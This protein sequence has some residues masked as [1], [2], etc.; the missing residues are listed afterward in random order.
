MNTPDAS[1]D[2]PVEKSLRRFY[3]ES[4]WKT[5]SSGATLD[6]QRW[7]DLRPCAAAYVSACRRRILAHLPKTGHV[8][9]DVASGPVQYP[10][11]AELSR[12]F[13]KHLCVDLSTRALEQARSRLGPRGLYVCAS[14]NHLPFADNT[15][16]AV[17]SLHTIYHVDADEQEASVRQ[18][19]RTVR[20]GGRVI[21]VYAN[22]DRL[23]SRLKRWLRP[24]R[25]APP[26]AIYYHAH[27]LTWWARFRD[28]ASLRILPWRSVVAQESKLLPA[29]LAKPALHVVLMLEGWFSSLAVRLGAY[30]MIILTKSKT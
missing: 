13:E 28:Q 11:Y 29:M 12:G 20:P 5:D 7:E 14:V 4:G 27:P 18:L 2:S 23:L 10:E 24:A 8:L 17:V 22:P 9:L 19:I 21:V 15:F 30:P 1:S 3:D 16:D 25:S 26:A 6:A